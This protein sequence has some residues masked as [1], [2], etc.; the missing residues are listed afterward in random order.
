MIKPVI[1]TLLDDAIP[2]TGMAALRETEWKS[3]IM[4]KG[5][6]VCCS[7]PGQ[8][9]E[10]PDAPVWLMTYGHTVWKPGN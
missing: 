9:W 10:L 7:G 2:A 6:P 3:S 8:S 1:Y 4:E 5:A